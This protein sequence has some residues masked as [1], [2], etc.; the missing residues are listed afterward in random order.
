M[1]QDKWIEQLHDKLADHE[2]AAPEGLWADIEAALAQQPQSPKTRFVALRRWAAAAAVAT[3]MVGGG[4]L[5]WSGGEVIVECGM[6]NVERDKT[7]VEG[8]MLNVEQDMSEAEVKAEAKVKT[9]P[10]VIS[11]HAPHS[12][13]NEKPFN[14]K[15]IVECGVLN[16]ERDMSEPEVTVEAEL[17][18]EAEIKTEPEVISLHTPHSTFN[19]KPLH[20]PHSTF[21]EKQLH[22]KPLNER[23]ISISLYA[24][25]GFSDQSNSNGVLM[26]DDQAKRF[27]EVYEQSNRTLARSREPIYLVGYEERQHHYQPISYGLTLNYPLTPRLSLTPGVVYTKLRSDFTH[28]VR[29]QQI[30]QEQTLS[31]V[32]I[33]A[34]A[35]YRLWDMGRLKCYVAAGVKADFNVAT[36]LEAEG[37]SQH[38][39]KDRPQWSFSGGVGVQYDV[40]PLLGLY[41]EPGISY[42]PDNGSRLMNYY[43]DKPLTF[44]LQL[45][46]RLNI[47]QP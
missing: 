40:L 21:N 27:A 47:S 39:D 35:N 19:E 13:F 4:W 1:K 36:H 11:L 10:K 30:R 41:A 8:G 33:M 29:S 44:S 38:L 32:G 24:M 14:E 5:W 17:K 25:N 16:V 15:E 7:I 18:A 45:G 6:L 28:I 31:Y 43:K 12:T 46:L 9:E 2:M 42:Y 23:K 26:A 34:G 20:T 3:L 37:V 22:E